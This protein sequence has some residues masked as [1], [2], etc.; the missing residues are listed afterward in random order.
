M[1]TY[2]AKPQDTER[3]WFV[4]DARDATLGRLASR[5]ATI[6]Q[7]KHKPTY[8]PHLDVGDHVVV[9][10][11]D[12]L[13]LTGTKAL[14]KVYQRYSGYPS[15]RRER[16]AKEQRA[17]DSTEMVRLAVKGMLPKSRLGH[18]MIKKLKVYRGAEHPHAA[19]QPET[20]SL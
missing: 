8:T 16:T 18:Q 2:S 4:A 13:R 17:I 14:T 11:A 20:L 5:V 3:A 19:Q 7:G 12:Q 6:L 1:K 9:V 15:G 10:N